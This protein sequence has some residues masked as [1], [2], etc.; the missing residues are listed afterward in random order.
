MEMLEI[1]SHHFFMASQFHGEFRSRPTNPSP[2]YLGFVKASL[3]KKHGKTRVETNESAR[4]A[5]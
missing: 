1:P 2:P 3:D 4:K 5:K